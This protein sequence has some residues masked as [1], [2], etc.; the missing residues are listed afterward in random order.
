MRDVAASVGDLNDPQERANFLS[1]VEVALDQSLA[2]QRRLHGRWAQDLFRAVLISL[3]GITM[4][5][6][7]D[8]GEF[9]M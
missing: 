2:N 3:D 6:D 8:S 4:I 5:K 7:E 9:Y 1:E